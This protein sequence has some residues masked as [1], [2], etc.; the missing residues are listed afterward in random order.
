MSTRK[1]SAPTRSSTTHEKQECR[2]CYGRGAVTQDVE[3]SYAIGWLVVEPMACP[4]CKGAGE[5]S[6]YLYPTVTS[7]WQEVVTAIPRFEIGELVATPGALSVLTPEE[8]LTLLSRHLAGD[9]GGVPPEDALENE[10]SVE[11]GFRI[12]SSYE[13]ASGATVWIIT[14][15]DRSSTCVLLPS[16]Y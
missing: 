13:V 6:V 9:W 3:Y 7:E 10:F 8:R 15:A 12:V 11:H 5:V 1:S 16:E 4:I 2:W 14:E